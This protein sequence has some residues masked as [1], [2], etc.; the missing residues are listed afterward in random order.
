MP[1]TSL[2]EVLEA[3]GSTG[4]GITSEKD[5]VALLDLHL[6]LVQECQHTDALERLVKVRDD[7]RK[8]LATTF[9]VRAESMLARSHADPLEKALGPLE[10]LIDGQATEEKGR[11]E[12]RWAQLGARVEKLVGELEA[13]RYIGVQDEGFKSAASSLRKNNTELQ[14]LKKGPDFEKANEVLDLVEQDLKAFD[15]A[16]SP[17]ND[18]A[19]KDYLV[20]KA[21]LKPAMEKLDA[22]LAAHKYGNPILD[23]FKQPVESYTTARDRMLKNE[24]DGNYLFANG[25]AKALKADIPKRQ[26]QILAA[27]TDAFHKRQG[28]AKKLLDGIGGGAFSGVDA[29]P[30][31]TALDRAEQAMKRVDSDDECAAAMATFDPIDDAIVAVRKAAVKGLVEAGTKTPKAA[32][33]KAMAMLEHDPEAMTALGDEPGGAELLDAMVSDL[34][35]KAKG[36]ENKR[37]VRA[38]ITA[39]FGTSLSNKPDDNTTKYLPRLYK[40]LGMVPAS[41]TLDNPML[42]NINRERTKLMPQ[43]DYTDGTGKINLEVPRTGFVDSLLSFGVRVLPEKLIGKVTHGKDIS[44]FDVLT[45]HEVGHSVDDKKQFMAGKAGN[46]TFGGWQKHTVDEIAQV[47]GDMLGFFKDCADQGQK[48]FLKA[49]LKAVLQKKKPQDEGDVTK[50]IKA[51]DKPDWK[52]LAKHAAVTH[53]ENIR[54]KNSDSGLWDKGDSG[55]SKWAIGSSVFQQSYD[56]DDNWV[57]YALS[58]RSSKI[59]DYQFRADGEWYAEAYAAFFVKKLKDSHPLHALLTKDQQSTEAAKRAKR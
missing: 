6:G 26:G 15:K 47:L 32:R 9:K 58:A 24:E 59:T 53:A 22:A 44:I 33:A 25:V 51:G 19:R 52:K 54:L 57:S 40:A 55:A 42:K 5:A 46:V 31:K 49:Y 21:E 13:S 12:K 8:A 23:V 10:R 36:A 35:G 39:R 14:G 1:K 17:V 20:A 34:G 3:I 56:G 11:F 41:H 45:L 43:G 50:E 29:K 2:R 38:A 16:F 7:A 30:L 4:P 27:L 18:K 28:P 37:F 48:S